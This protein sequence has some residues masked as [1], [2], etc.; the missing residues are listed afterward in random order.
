[1]GSVQERKA[2]PVMTPNTWGISRAAAMM[3]LKPARDRTP[4]SAEKTKP[5]ERGFVME[6][7]AF[8]SARPLYWSK[9]S[10]FSV[11]SEIAHQ[12]PLLAVQV[13]RSFVVVTAPHVA[14][15]LADPV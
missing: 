2:V 4:G 8:L 9:G 3:A 14:A 6:H 15:L 7:G 12:L 5:R 11:I 13:M 10:H 1:M